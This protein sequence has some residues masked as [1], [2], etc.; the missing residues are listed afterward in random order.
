MKNG[1]EGNLK[2]EEWLAGQQDREDIIGNLA[3]VLSMQNI[4]HKASRR[5]PD[6]H[7]SWVDIVL[8]ITEPG[9]IYVFNEA[10]QEF[11]L[12]K[13]SAGDSLD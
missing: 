2:F 1:E 8:N 6:E 13:Q 4:A 9:Y 3:R 12:A 5:K 7:K 11:L 10:W